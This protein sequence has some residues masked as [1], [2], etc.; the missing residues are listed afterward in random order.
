MREFKIKLY[1]K[2]I[3]TLT[4]TKEAEHERFGRVAP[5]Y[6]IRVKIE[7]KGDYVFPEDQQKATETVKRIACKYDLVV[8]VVDLTRENALRRIL[9]KKRERIK[10]FP[11]LIASSGQRELKAALQKSR[12]RS[13]SLVWLK[14][15]GKRK[16][17]LQTSLESLARFL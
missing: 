2:S 12:L 15:S 6:P 8:E 7:G 3:K 9:Q 1:V 17:A 11:T 5:A 16:S 4:G 10:N 14:L 13:Y